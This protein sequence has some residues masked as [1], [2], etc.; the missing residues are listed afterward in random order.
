[1]ITSTETMT[2]WSVGARLPDADVTVMVTLEDESEPCWPGYFDGEQWIEASTG[3]PFAVRVIAW[4]DM[5][6]GFR[7]AAPTLDD[8]L[9]LE[10]LGQQRLALE[11]A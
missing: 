11:T 3:G 10:R 4:A 9:E 8:V 6:A 5:P 1:M 7:P 2:W